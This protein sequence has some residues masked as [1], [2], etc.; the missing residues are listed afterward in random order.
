MQSQGL[1]A[2]FEDFC[3]GDSRLSVFSEPSKKSS[4][5]L[6]HECAEVKVFQFHEK[7]GIPASEKKKPKKKSRGGIGGLSL[8]KRRRQQNRIRKSETQIQDL[9][10]EFRVN[11]EWSKEKVAELSERTGL[12]E[13]QV[14]KWNWDQRKKFTS[15]MEQLEAEVSRDE[16]GGYCC[17]K[18]GKADDFENDDNICNLLGLD[19]N[20]MALELVKSDL[21]KRQKV[22]NNNAHVKQTSP[23]KLQKKEPAKQVN[24]SHIA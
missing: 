12:S 2:V 1:V 9:I 22:K 5:H 18:W 11:P 20:T 3:S 6:E 15:E 7:P 24:T 19:I 23:T 16:F 4:S 13:S 8:G 10:V 14:Y 21:E 17:K